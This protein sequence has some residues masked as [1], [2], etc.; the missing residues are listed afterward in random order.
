MS[1]TSIEIPDNVTLCEA[2]DRVLQKGA[3]V[4][5]EVTIS[6]ADIDLIYINL[7]LMISSISKMQEDHNDDTSVT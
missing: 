1:D 4:L 6:V 2:L 3:V 5:G 7:R